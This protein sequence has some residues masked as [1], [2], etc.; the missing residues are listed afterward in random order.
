LHEMC[1]F[2]TV[3]SRPGSSSLRDPFVYSSREPSQSR[4]SEY[5][6]IQSGRCVRKPPPP[7]RMVLPA[8]RLSERLIRRPFRRHSR[9][10]TARVV[11]ELPCNRHPRISDRTAVHRSRSERIVTRFTTARS[12][13][14]ERQTVDPR[15][16]PIQLTGRRLTIPHDPSTVR[17][18][19]N[20]RATSSIR[21][22]AAPDRQR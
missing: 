22:L 16:S 9:R 8:E 15:S 4:T 5:F 10:K 14:A 6:R 21:E 18:S 19:A 13:G 17:A 11:Y 3:R 12:G 1:K 7:V 2:R 20:D